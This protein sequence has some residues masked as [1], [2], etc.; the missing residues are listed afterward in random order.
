MRLTAGDRAR[1]VTETGGQVG[2]LFAFVADDLGEH[3][4]AAH[5]RVHVN[6]LFPRVGEQFV[7]TARQPILTLVE[8]TSPGHHDMLVP[9]CDPA[10][11]R[12]LGQHGW[13]ASCAENLRTATDDIGHRL[14]VVPQ[15]VNLFMNIPVSRDGGLDWLPS[16]AAAG[17][18][19]TLEAV[20]D[21]LV[22]LSACPQ[23]LVEINDGD[24]GPL[25]LEVPTTA[26]VPH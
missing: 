22:V 3:L 24:P 13:H 17:A 6:R 9:A 4:S 7:T 14:E 5:T 10:R 16:Q 12:S 15:P 18:S 11:Y 1:V 25:V 19:V 2:D 26:A 8:D 21:C 20:R 23:D